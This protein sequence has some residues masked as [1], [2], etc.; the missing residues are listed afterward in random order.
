MTRCGITRSR[1]AARGT[2]P[3]TSAGS[4]AGGC[5][6]RHE[7][8]ALI[9]APPRS[10]A[11]KTSSLV[12][13][14]VISQQT[15]LV[16][17][18]TKPDVVS[19]TAIARGWM[20]RL[21]C[22]APDGETPIPPGMHELRWSPLSGAE[23]WATAIRTAR[24]MTQTLAEQDRREAHWA[25]RARDVLAPVFHWAALSGEGMREAR[26]MVLALTNEIDVQGENVRIGRWIVKQLQD[27]ESEG[28]DP[29][30]AATLRN[31]MALDIRELSGIV[32]TAS[33]AL[34]VYQIP[35]AL[36]STEDPNFDPRA[37]VRRWWG[38]ST[39]YIIS[40]GE[41]Q[42]SVSPL[43]VALLNQIRREQYILHREREAEP[44]STTFILDEM[45]NIAPIP[46]RDLVSLLSEG[47]SQGLVLMAA[48]QDLALIKDR[49]QTAGES[50]L[51]LFG[52]V[53]I[54]PGIRHKETLEAVSVLCGEYDAPSPT[55]SV[56][57]PG[58]GQPTHTYGT[59]T[60]R[61]RRMTPDMVYAG[62]IPEVPA[63]G[64]HLSGGE[65]GT[66]VATPYYKAKPWPQVLTYYVEWAMSSPTPSWVEMSREAGREF[67]E[68]PLTDLPLPDLTTWIQ[69]C[70][71][72]DRWAD[73][74]TRGQQELFRPPPRPLG[75]PS[76]ADLA[77]E[78]RVREGRDEQDAE[79]ERHHGGAVHEREQRRESE[80]EAHHDV[81]AALEQRGVHLLGLRR[82]GRRL[83]WW[84]RDAHHRRAP[85]SRWS[86]HCG[87][88]FHE[89]VE[90]GLREKGPPLTASG[91]TPPREP[92][93]VG[94]RT[95][96]PQ[97]PIP[98]R[99]DPRSVHRPR[100]E[101]LGRSS[102]GCAL[103]R[104]SR[105][106][107]R[108]SGDRCREAAPRRASAR[109]A[110]RRRGWSA[111][112]SVGRTSV[113]APSTNLW[114]ADRGMRIRRPILRCG[115][116]PRFTAS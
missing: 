69:Q 114:S 115:I 83:R 55:H 91:G 30:A 116:S 14:A 62:P 87:S 28:A 25:D 89:L 54:F 2:A 59:S 27:L 72:R 50:F 97:L 60:N 39:I 17:T 101:S 58:Q 95:R 41:E 81:V 33:R 36:K 15:P 108:G 18:S 19:A 99:V 43:V 61:R 57:Y 79:H 92:T 51:T 106:R 20:G 45:A 67:D 76:L 98:T 73:K 10:E 65:V 8:H 110:P 16:V 90:R 32:S 23:D 40:A 63:M 84:R 49:W 109:R 71:G 96:D 26:D 94:E 46:K 3:S 107:G 13:P 9:L 31:V 102:G 56:A 113:V 44:W 34:Q 11:G 112:H 103:S 38:A 105:N 37:F 75:P 42:E 88:S 47:G 7:G 85:V 80:T 86:V 78:P 21:W 70:R 35:A 12:A 48:V 22:Y 53:V 104:R 77:L 66:V 93:F 74:W 111:V 5:R 64:I 100:P 24:S 6:R 4:R 29:T 52:D 82:L 68:P 1:C